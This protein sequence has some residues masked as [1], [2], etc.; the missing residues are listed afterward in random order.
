LK[1]SLD[2]TRYH[3]SR[4]HLPRVLAQHDYL[5]T[6]YR[7]NDTTRIRLM[8]EQT[9]GQLKYKPL[10]GRGVSPSSYNSPSEPSAGHR[11][12]PAAR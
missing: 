9:G 7:L 2:G 11:D 6:T 10:T 12:T 5:R 1:H 3:V 4:E 8:I